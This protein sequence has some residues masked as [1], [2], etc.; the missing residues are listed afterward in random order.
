[1]RCRV[2]GRGPNPIDGG[3]TVYNYGPKT[4]PVVWYCRDDYPAP[5]ELEPETLE[6]V[7][8]IEGQQ[9]GS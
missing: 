4:D 5:S 7:D 6:I 3:I 9:K 1:M 8:L 2:C